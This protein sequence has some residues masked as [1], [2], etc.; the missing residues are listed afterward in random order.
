MCYQKHIPQKQH[1]HWQSYQFFPTCDVPLVIISSYLINTCWA[2]WTS[3]VY[4]FRTIVIVS[5]LFI[6]KCTVGPVVPNF[7]VACI[8]SSLLNSHMLNL[9]YTNES[10]ATLSQLIVSRMYWISES[11][12]ERELRRNTQINL[13]VKSLRQRNHSVMQARIHDL[14]RLS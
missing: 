6:Y 8:W 2:G 4:C 3:I 14:P 1:M 11:I 5:C 12:L 7:R 13:V 9:H 10:Y